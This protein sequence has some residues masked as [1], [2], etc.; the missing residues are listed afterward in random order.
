MGKVKDIESV[1]SFYKYGD[2]GILL[3]E[4]DTLS[5][6]WKIK[7]TTENH[8]VVS[9][10]FNRS[11]GL[12]AN[13]PDEVVLNGLMDFSTTIIGKE[14][15]IYDTIDMF[16]DRCFDESVF[17]KYTEKALWLSLDYPRYVEVEEILSTYNSRIYWP[18]NDGEMC[19]M[20]DVIIRGIEKDG[21]V[22]TAS[23]I[24]DMMKEHKVSSVFVG[25]DNKMKDYIRKTE[26]NDIP[27]FVSTFKGNGDFNGFEYF[28]KD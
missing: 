6:L 15:S 20:R 1:N 2:E 11:V 16:I 28:R 18:A 17:G 23:E 7:F 25:I 24:V 21:Y 13:A 14:L 12:Y 27:C 10:E 4:Q 26:F 8:Y 3:I 22:T 5:S 9:R 19:L